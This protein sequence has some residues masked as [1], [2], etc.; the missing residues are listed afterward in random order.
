MPSIMI[1]PETLG[2]IQQKLQLELAQ[3]AIA[4]L[5]ILEGLQFI[6][7][8]GPRIAIDG[9]CSNVSERGGLKRSILLEL[10]TH[11]PKYSGD[12]YFPVPHP[13]DSPDLAYLLADDM[14]CLSTEYA[15]NRWELLDF[16]ISLIDLLLTS[17]KFNHGK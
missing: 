7:D 5:S 10:C 2:A 16:L 4:L 12:Y 3:N 14:W 13:V 6:R 15:R 9:I 17:G 1:S 11:W 8:H